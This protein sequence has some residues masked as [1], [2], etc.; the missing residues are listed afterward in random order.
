[1]DDEGR[2]DLVELSRADRPDE[3]ALQATL[4]VLV[5]HDAAALQAAP[6]L[7]GVPQDVAGGRL[8]SDLFLF[9]SRELLR[10]RER[11]LGKVAERNI[12]NSSSLRDSQDETLRPC[13]LDFYGK[14]ASDRDGVSFFSRFECRNFFRGFHE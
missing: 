4:L 11:Q 9:A 14:S 13:R 8:L 6:E 7:E 2:R 5:R 1:M 10:L 12:A 3:V